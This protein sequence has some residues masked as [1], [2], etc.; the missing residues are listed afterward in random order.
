M[1]GRTPAGGGGLAAKIPAVPAGSDGAEPGQYGRGPLAV[2]LAAACWGTSGVFVKLVAAEV[3]VS[4]LA[5]AFWR[6]LVT[7]LV[8][9][10][11]LGLLRRGWLRV[12]RPDLPWL[13]ALG[14]SLG[15]FHVFWN[16]GVFLN[17]AAVATVQQAAM[18]AI[19]AVV[20]WLIWHEALT[21]SKI[22]AILLTFV[23]TVL[24]SGLEA[25]GQAQLSPGSLLIGLSIPVTYAAWNLF[26]KKVRQTYNPF[27]TL[28]YAFAFGALVL[29]PLQFFTPQPWP[30]PPAGLLWF[31]ALIAISTLFP[32]IIYTFA[33][34]RL[35]ASV[36]TILAMSEIAFV[37]AY[38][39]V[40][41]GERLSPSQILGAVLVVGGVLLLSLQ[42]W[43]QRAQ[44]RNR[45]TPAT[46]EGEG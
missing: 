23:G 2:V 21:W 31:T 35:P 39:Y 9:L 27:A 5:L 32:F 25:L 6:D 14:G 33:L 11:G 1:T 34:G 20:A 24:V 12:Q 16:L 41:L 3:E 40:L 19:V 38:A 46:Q 45:T 10:T 42:R 7:F 18:P 43:R 44:P 4:A 8:L 22:A 26:G 17:G 13:I 28:T 29:L 15:T 37:A 36:A 30:V